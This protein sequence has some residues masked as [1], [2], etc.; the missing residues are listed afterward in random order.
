LDITIAGWDS[1]LGEID[2]HDF[3]VLQHA[4][5]GSSRS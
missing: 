3:D 5:G 1:L 4:N 2:I